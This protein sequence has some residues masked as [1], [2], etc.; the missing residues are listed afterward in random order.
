MTYPLYKDL[1]IQ[2]GAPPGSSWGVFDTNGTKDAYGTLNF[3]T[4]K[5]VIAAKAEIQTGESVVLNLPMH[6]P[7]GAGSIG[8][9]ETKHSVL[10]DVHGAQCCDDELHFNTQSSSQWDGLLHFAN[11]SLGKYYNGVPYEDAAKSF[12][13]KSLGI[14]ALSKRGGI[15]ARGILVDFVRYAEK[16]NIKYD[17]LGPYAIKLHQIK[18]IL[19]DQGTEIRDG[20]ILLVRAGISKYLHTCKP[21][22]KSPPQSQ[23]HVGI[24]PEPELLEWIWNSH[25]A[26]VGGDSLACEAVPAYD[27]TFGKLHSACIPGW[28]MMIGELLDLE[29]LSELAAKN[30]RWSFFMTICPINVDGGVATLS[31]TIAVM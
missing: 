5:A 9:R 26:A 10:S 17:P 29:A 4:P 8:R 15:V 1:P 13:D 22:D 12:T 18:D 3:I 2:D 23:T 27:G 31:N 28:G 24:D 11:Q 30:N 6:L 16:N 21:E 19:A 25:F 14:Q 20:D 7:H